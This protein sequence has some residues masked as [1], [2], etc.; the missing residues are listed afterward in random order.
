[1]ETRPTS[2]LPLEVQ[3]AANR[4]MR[5]EAERRGGPPGRLVHLFGEIASVDFFDHPALARVDQISPVLAMDIPVFT[6]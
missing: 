4:E 3:P 5:W 6:K 1:M 2:S